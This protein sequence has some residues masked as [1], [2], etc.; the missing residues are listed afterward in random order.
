M[1]NSFKGNI[2]ITQSFQLNQRCDRCDHPLIHSKYE[3]DILDTFDFILPQ[4]LLYNF[5]KEVN[6]FQS[7]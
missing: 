2:G 7:F 5:H 1:G 6:A 3:D 4:F